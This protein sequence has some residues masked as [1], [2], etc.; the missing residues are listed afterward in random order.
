MTAKDMI[1]EL[2]LRGKIEPNEHVAL[3]L[4]RAK[5]ELDILPTDEEVEEFFNLNIPVPEEC[6]SSSAIYKF[7]LWLKDRIHEK[8]ND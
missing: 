3:Q 8:D 5:E 7:R 6:S 1:D 4:T 2:L